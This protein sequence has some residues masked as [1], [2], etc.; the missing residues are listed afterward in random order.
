MAT[1]FRARVSGVFGNR[2]PAHAYERRVGHGLRAAPS[3][4]FPSRSQSMFSFDLSR[5]GRRERER[6]RTSPKRKGKRMHQTTGG[7]K[8]EGERNFQRQFPPLENQWRAQVS[9]VAGR[10]GDRVRECG[11]DRYVDKSA[12]ES[13]QSKGGIGVHE[14]PWP[15]THLDG[16]LTG[17]FAC[18]HISVLFEVV[19]C[20][21]SG[22][23]GPFCARS[24][25]HERKK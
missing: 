24:A 7:D 8:R 18:S 21:S 25:V 6:G 3:R 9:G 14:C 13:R 22:A 15:P 10:D 2:K 1:V 16:G 11:E 4:A 12:P 19:G 23:R 20:G 5:G 17:C